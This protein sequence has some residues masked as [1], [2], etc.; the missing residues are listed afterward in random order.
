M[1]SAVRKACMQAALRKVSS[2]AKRARAA[3]ACTVLLTLAA[4]PSVAHAL[5][6]TLTI[7]SPVGGLVTNNPTPTFS[8]ETS[9][10]YEPGV[11]PVKLNIYRGSKPE[12]ELASSPPT[13]QPKFGT[14]WSATVE[15][16]LEPGTYTAR[17]EQIEG[18]E[19]GFSNTVT[20]TVYT[21]RP[22]VKITYPANDSSATGESQL[23]TGS[24][25]TAPRD[26][27]SVT[28]ELFAGATIAPAALATLEV[29]VSGASWSA[30]FAP[31]RPGTYTAEAI[32]GDEAGNT[33]TS[34]VTF[35]L[36]A[37]PAQSITPPVASFSWFPPAPVVGQTVVLVSGSTDATSPLRAFEWD[38]AGGGPFQPGGQ[39][40]STS[41]ASPGNHVVR[42][43]VTDA[44]G[45]SNVATETLPVGLPPLKPMQPFPIV[46]I[47]GVQ[48]AAGVRLSL[49]SVQAPVGARVT[50]AC[51]GRACR[52]KP[53]SRLA[54]ASRRN[55]HASSVV[56]AFVQFERSFRAGTT[57]E[58]RVSAPGEI[59]KYTL[60]AIHRHSLPT[61]VDECLAALAP[62]PVACST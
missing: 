21:E 43:R 25:G 12:G 9:A 57:L 36:L 2:S 27:R 46:R 44:A 3:A 61:R 52:M 19:T 54:I 7:A 15:V 34:I 31:L 60:F 24:A 6:P 50:V 35:M 13:E 56:L 62:N 45:A 26:N 4:A 30:V 38:L 5:P 22:R 48:T 53:Q 37:P 42:L 18:I 10:A 17:A 59:G 49:L 1:I 11:N 55:K 41:F 28:V 20:F 32:Q 14:V 8:G 29:P 51:K 58:V 39:V 40:L 47:A 16:P 23:L 33:G